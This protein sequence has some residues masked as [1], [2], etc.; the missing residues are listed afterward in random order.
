MAGS[1]A[2]ATHPRLQALLDKARRQGPVR[3]AV[4][5]PVTAEVLQGVGEAMSHGLLE[6][7][8][9]GPASRIQAAA[10]KARVD[11]KGVVVVDTEH[12]HA[13]ADA[14]VAMARR[15]EVDILVKGSLPTGELLGAIL[16]RDNGI[17]TDR[18]I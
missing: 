10:K 7:V 6:P 1:S 15:H 17:R 3:A 12:S 8:L 13:A 5:H 9:V 11:I 14:A 16:H 18:R 2:K 4:I